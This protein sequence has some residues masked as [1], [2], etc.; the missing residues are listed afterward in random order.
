M[1][2]Y[3]KMMEWMDT[4]CTTPTAACNG[5][6]PAYGSWYLFRGEKLNKR[7]GICILYIHMLTKKGEQKEK[8]IYCKTHIQFSQIN[9]L[10]R[11]LE[12]PTVLFQN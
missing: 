7:A 4:F 2:L 11:Q 6:K 12:V 1:Q 3:V 9:D 5:V 8:A 10:P